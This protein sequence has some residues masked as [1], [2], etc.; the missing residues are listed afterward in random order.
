MS[1]RDR[2]RGQ[3][4]GR[5]NRRQLVAGAGTAGSGLVIALASK[6]AA[7]SSSSRYGM[8]GCF[9]PREPLTFQLLAIKR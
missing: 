4:Q 5:V 2:V 7:A 1:S 3:W 8:P 6:S 9:A